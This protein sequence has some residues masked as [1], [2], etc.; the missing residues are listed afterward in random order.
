MNQHD[1]RKLIGVD[2][3]KSDYVPVACLLRSGY[4]C[5]GYYNKGLNQDLEDTCVLVNAR[6]VGLN[7]NEGSAYRYT[8]SDFN[9]FIEQIVRG[10]QTNE[11]DPLKPRGDAFGQTIPLTAVPFREVAIVYP[12]AYINLM[13]QRLAKEQ[14]AKTEKKDDKKLPAFLDLDQ[15]ET[16]KILRT[17]LW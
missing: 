6:L 4:A 3:V 7:S 9:D 10:F 1:F 12:V 15:S 11:K 2:V 16:L 13:M 17:K 5:A 8:V 14:V